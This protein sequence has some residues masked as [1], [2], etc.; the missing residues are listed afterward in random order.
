MVHKIFTLP[1]LVINIIDHVEGNDLHNCLTV[2][3]L[4]GE[5]TSLNILKREKESIQKDLNKI[6]KMMEWIEKELDNLLNSDYDEYEYGEC[7]NALDAKHSVIYRLLIIFKVD[8]EL[9]VRSLV[10][11]PVIRNLFRSQWHDLWRRVITQEKKQYI[12]WIEF[13]GVPCLPIRYCPNFLPTE[14]QTPEIMPYLT[15]LL[16]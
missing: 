8:L 5:V 16:I 15:N 6:G 10:R 7:D 1:E 12:E 2:N 13:S 3:K 14:F 9:M 11:L 4:W